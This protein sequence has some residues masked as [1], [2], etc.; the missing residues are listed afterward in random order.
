[1]TLLGC[2]ADDF[3]GA[4][5]L[6]SMLV[7]N[8]MRTVQLIGVP[9]PGIPVPEADAIVVALKSRT[10]P[11][12]DAVEQSLAA[13]NWLQDAGCRQFFFKYCST[14]DST[15]AGN[16]GPVA[17]ALIAALDC[18][19]AIA[20]PAF[21][22]N[23]RSVYQG[24]LFVGAALLNESGMQDHPLTPMRDANLV[25]VLSRQSEGTVGLVSFATVQ[26]GAGPIRDA[27]TR[28]REQGRRFAIV[29]AIADHHLVSIG[30][31]VSNHA[32]IT[33]GSGVAMGLPENFRKL[34]LLPDESANDLP[35]VSGPAAVLAG[36]CSRATLLQIATCRDQLPTLEL[37]ALKTPD[38]GD[39][40][41]QALDWAQSKLGDTPIVIAA[42]A[43]PD[44]VAALQAKIGRDAAGALVEAAMAGIAKE[45]VARGVRRMVVAGGETSG[46]VVSA[47]AIDRL[48]I[49]PE[50]D[51]GVPW[52][53]AEGSGPP[54]LLALKSGNFG[55]PQFFRAA[56][57]APET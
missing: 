46:A 10:I 49:G 43:T 56:F 37:D 4:T 6:A 45:L 15:E 8:G 40:I 18:G 33:G 27:L 13:L 20:C 28:L 47:L 26:A 29:D 22:A 19:F 30:A 53:Y 7:R 12:A 3:T 34:G 21:P 35:A 23:A 44:R 41:Q 36:S 50:I 42:S 1:M 48:R 9:K 38:A 55:G 54:L 2:M 11:A 17:E 31:A 52:T 14:F 16:I 39:L 51:P 32:L 24:H 57:T 5:D 25:R